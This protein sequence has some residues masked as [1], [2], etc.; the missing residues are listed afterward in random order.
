MNKAGVKGRLPADILQGTDGYD[1]WYADAYFKK[2]SPIN[3]LCPQGYFLAPVSV[4]STQTQDTP[5]YIVGPSSPGEPDQDFT[6]A[7]KPLPNCIGPYS[8]C[9]PYWNN[10][11]FDTV[12]SITSNA[13]SDYRFQFNIST[14]TILTCYA[15]CNL[16]IGLYQPIPPEC[17]K[18]NKYS[19]E[20]SCEVPPFTSMPPPS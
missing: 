15:N 1:D 5:Y 7:V 11:N 3:N 8:Y 16:H 12:F 19:T 10:Y 13:A 20:N 2:Y 17:S 18:S 6:G 4:T 14:S 9:Y